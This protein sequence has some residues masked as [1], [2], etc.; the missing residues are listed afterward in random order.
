M[1]FDSR[2]NMNIRWYAMRVDWSNGG[3]TTTMIDGPMEYDKCVDLCQMIAGLPEW[4]DQFDGY[5]I[6]YSIPE[7]GYEAMVMQN[8]IGRWIPDD[9]PQVDT[10][11]GGDITEDI[12]F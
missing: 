2:E 7:E 6:L 12:P 4:N 9:F 10:S 11:D 3:T 1:I 5:R 8:T